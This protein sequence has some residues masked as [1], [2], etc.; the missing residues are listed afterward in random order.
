[1]IKSNSVSEAHAFTPFYE[2]TQVRA[3][4]LSRNIQNIFHFIGK[5]ESIWDTY[6]H[7]HPTFTTDHRNGDVADDSYHLWRRD[8]EMIKSLGVSGYRMSISWPR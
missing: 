5:G 7:E 3:A 2:G 6:L 4:L 8:I 1:M